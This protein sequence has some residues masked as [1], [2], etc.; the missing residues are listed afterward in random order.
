METVT[1]VTRAIRREMRAHRPVGLSMQ[2]FRALGIVR[3][4]PGAS[5]SQVAERLGLT[6]ASSSRLVES[7]AKAGF[8]SRI[9]SPLDRRR[10][11]LRVT[12]SGERALEMAR[13]AALGRLAEMLAA[14]DEAERSGLERAMQT[15]RAMFVGEERTGM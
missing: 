10:V 6:V 3:R 14:L 2:Q 11:E 12:D 9:D 5:L 8:M 7:L 4:H 1:A 13:S 15:L